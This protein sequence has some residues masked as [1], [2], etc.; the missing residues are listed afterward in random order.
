MKQRHAFAIAPAPLPPAPALGHTAALPP[1]TLATPDLSPFIEF[2]H[3]YSVLNENIQ[4][5]QPTEIDF[6]TQRKIFAIHPQ[7]PCNLPPRALQSTHK[8]LAIY[9]QEPCNLPPRAL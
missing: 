3:F 6:S 7:E 4:H 9:P 1:L 5:M 2:C 8:I